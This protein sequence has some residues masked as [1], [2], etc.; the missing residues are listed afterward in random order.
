MVSS[1]GICQAATLTCQFQ[2]II[3]NTGGS[4]GT[5]TLRLLDMGRSPGLVCIAVTQRFEPGDSGEASCTPVG[6]T[7]EAQ[8]PIEAKIE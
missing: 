6:R 2:A 4:A 3:K 1:S 7:L 5:A 8:P